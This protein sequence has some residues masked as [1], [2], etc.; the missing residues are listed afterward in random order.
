MTMAFNC[1]AVLYGTVHTSV[2][3]ADC[4]VAQLLLAQV[5]HEVLHVVPIPLW[6]LRHLL[7]EA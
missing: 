2:A 4:M 6:M 7:V 1:I 3:N 5:A